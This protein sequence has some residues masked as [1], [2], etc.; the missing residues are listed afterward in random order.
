MKHGGFLWLCLEQHARHRFLRL[1]PVQGY[2]LPLP[3]TP[4][5]ALDLWEHAYI[6]TYGG[7][8]RA[9]ADAFLRQLD[10]ENIGKM[11]G[12]TGDMRQNSAI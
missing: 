1:I 7:D 12:D 6:S 5:L 4:I 10:W 11:L 8:R 2:E 9:Y 3:L